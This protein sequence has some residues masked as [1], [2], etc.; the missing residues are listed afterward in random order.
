MTQEGNYTRA[1]LAAYQEQLRQVKRQREQVEALRNSPCFQLFGDP[2]EQALLKAEQI[3]LNR[4]EVTL[5]WRRCVATAYLN[6]VTDPITR[7]FLWQRYIAGLSWKEIA[8]QYGAG[9][10]ESMARMATVRYMDRSP[11]IGIGGSDSSHKTRIK[12]HYSNPRNGEE[13]LL[14]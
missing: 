11:L 13:I 3:R 1:L 12:N 14:N 7:M 8:V 4:M 10:S 2:R 9:A 6:S 5:T